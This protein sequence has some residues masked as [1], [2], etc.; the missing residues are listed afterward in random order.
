MTLE[1]K[2]FPPLGSGLSHERGTIS[3]LGP[4]ERAV[5]RFYYAGAAEALGGGRFMVRVTDPETKGRLNRA[6]VVK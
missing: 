3:G 1:V 4:G 5:R 2:V 6:A